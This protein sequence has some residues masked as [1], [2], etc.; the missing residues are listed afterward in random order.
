MMYVTPVIWPVTKLD[1]HPLIKTIML[2][3]NPI[4]GVITNARGAILG[5]SPVDWQVL[6]I[7]LL[8]SFVFFVL[9]LYYFRNTERYFA[10]IV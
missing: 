1:G 4:A 9:G 2:W 5:R 8:M 3:L 6:G 10:D 7:S